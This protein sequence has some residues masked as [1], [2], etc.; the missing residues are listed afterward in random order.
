MKPHRPYRVVFAFGSFLALLVLGLVPS[1]ATV[2]SGGFGQLVR[3]EQLGF[4]PD[5]LRFPGNALAV[6]VVQNQEDAPIQHEISSKELFQ[7]GTLVSVMGTGKIESDETRVS[8]IILS[9]GEEVV[10]VFFAEKGRTY[11]FQC[12]LNGH[13]MKANIRAF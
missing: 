2:S 1:E 7:P 13:A 4:Y 9:P 8:R 5:T 3:I 11:S 6:L 10:I 12:D